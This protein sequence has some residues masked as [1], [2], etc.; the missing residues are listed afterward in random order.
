MTQLYL[1]LGI[2]ENMHIIESASSSRITSRESS[3][4]NIFEDPSKKNS[5]EDKKSVDVDHW[6]QSTAKLEKTVKNDMIIDNNN[7]ETPKS[8]STVVIMKEH[9]PY[10]PRKLR[11]KLK[12]SKKPLTLK[13]KDDEESIED[14]TY[15]F[16]RA[17]MIF[18][19]RDIQKQFR[20]ETYP[21]MRLNILVALVA[22][23]IFEIFSILLVMMLYYSTGKESSMVLIMNYVAVGVQVVN[24]IVFLTPLGKYYL[25]GIVCV[26][27]SAI[28]HYSFT[29]ALHFERSEVD[30]HLWVAIGSFSVFTICF[31]PNIPIIV[32]F[33]SILLIS[34]IGK[35]ICRNSIIT[36]KFSTTILE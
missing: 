11:E 6:K 36:I 27:V 1:V 3:R 33:L 35:I 4:E 17:L 8:P 34:I 32:I 25:V 19:N 28:G 14:N 18:K 13:M 22:T 12:M 5:I 24:I 29:I 15:D 26:I 9:S 20:R 10:V 31:P 16:I 23:L 30:D 7:K 2:K 21:K